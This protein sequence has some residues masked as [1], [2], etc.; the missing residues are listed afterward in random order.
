MANSQSARSQKLDVFPPR[1]LSW[2]KRFFD[3]VGAV[4]ILV[5]SAPLM[6]VVALL[7]ILDSPGK[8]LYRQQRVGQGGLPFKMLKF[9]SMY[10]PSDEKLENLLEDNPHYRVNWQQYQ[11][12]LKDPRLTPVGRIIRRLSIDELPQLWNVLKGE[13]SLVGPRPILQEQVDIYGDALNLYILS[14]PGITGLWQINGRNLISFSERVRWDE[15][16]IN[17]WNLMLDIYILARS[18]GV[19]LRGEGAY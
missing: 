4:I 3:I 8:V 10:S 16:Y 15:Y 9:R 18:I 11:K 17:H 2:A 14:R 13:M 6:M 7:I 19:V 1:Y 5:L 12:L